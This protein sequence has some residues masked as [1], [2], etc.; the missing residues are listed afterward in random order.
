[1]WQR[2][3]LKK[4]QSAV[5]PGNQRALHACDAIGLPWRQC[6]SQP[7]ERHAQSRV[8]CGSHNPINRTSHE[9]KLHCEFGWECRFPWRCADIS[10]RLKNWE[11]EGPAS[12]WS[13]WMPVFPLLFVLP[14]GGVA[15]YFWPLGKT[16]LHK[17]KSAPWSH[18]TPWI[19]NNKIYFRGSG[20][21]TD[22][23]WTGF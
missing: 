17:P 20:L 8:P 13:M 23:A 18:H 10:H 9:C 7:T 5:T 15:Q 19:K 22:L 12:A 21:G 14:V 4:G 2:R 1:M 16:T 3:K 6:I 11:E